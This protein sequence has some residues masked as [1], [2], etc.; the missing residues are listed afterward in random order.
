MKKLLSLF[1][2]LLALSLTACSEDHTPASPK[3]IACAKEAVEI[4]EDYLS[5]DIDYQK[6]SERLDELREDMAYVS[7]MS[8]DD[9]HYYGDFAIQCDLLSLSSALVSDNHKSTNETYDKI[10][11]IIDG[12]KEDIE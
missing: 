3:A 10:Q 12:I 9:E 4:A 7:D 5:Y 2:I 11:E 8:K 1:T 6:A